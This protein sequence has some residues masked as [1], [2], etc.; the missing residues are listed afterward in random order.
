[1]KHGMVSTG[2]DGIYWS[3]LLR[4]DE[5]TISEMRDQERIS[6]DLLKM[7]PF[8]AFIVVPGAELLLPAYLK[9]FPNA[10]PTGFLTA[11]QMQDR[12]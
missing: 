3:R 8:S 2:K 10:I 9:L 4:K 1:V 11:T 5:K 7:I 12:E 6:G